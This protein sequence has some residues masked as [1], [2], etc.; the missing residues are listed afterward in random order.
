MRTGMSRVTDDI[1]ERIAALP[2]M[3]RLAP[4]VAG[5]VANAGEEAA[6]EFA[7]TYADTAVDA[8]LGRETPGLLS[9]ELLGEAAQSALGGAAG[10]GL[11]GGISSGIG[12]V[13]D[14]RQGR[15]AP[16]ADLVANANLSAAIERAGQVGRAQQAAAGAAQTQQERQAA[17]QVQQTAPGLLQNP[18]QPTCSSVLLTHDWLNWQPRAVAAWMPAPGEP[19]SSRRL[20][21]LNR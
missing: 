10:G 15:I 14:V 5:T 8:L 20:K 4:A 3:D 11:I 16:R 9:G 7:Q 18:Q 13:Q 6:E 12:A 19:C 21:T 1:L 2:G 17:A